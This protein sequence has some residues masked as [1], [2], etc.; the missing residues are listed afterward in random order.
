[1]THGAL[2]ES[3]RLS[4]RTS[5]FMTANSAEHAPN[6]TGGMLIGWVA[7]A[8]LHIVEATPPGPHAEHRPAVFTRD[9]PFSQAQ[10]DACVSASDGLHDYV[11]EWHSHPYPM[12]PSSKDVASMRRISERA[13]YQCPH[14]VML[15]CRRSRD[16]WRID[17]FQW[18]GRRLLARPLE[19]ID[20]VLP[21]CG[22]PSTR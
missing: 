18:D 2:I 3:I 12:G 9:G 14:P 8:I 19:A 21:A 15:L 22:A 7:G 4:V 11:G 13:T 5:T 1:M 17:G 20:D 6:E 10:L 16:G